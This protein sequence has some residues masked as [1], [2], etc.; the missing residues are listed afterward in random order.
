MHVEFA[1]VEGIVAHEREVVVR[2]VE[3][4]EVGLRLA[5]RSVE[6]GGLHHLLG[7]GGT[8]AQAAATVHDIFA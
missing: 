2:S 5:E 6:F 3:G 7:I 8:D 1:E 4:Q